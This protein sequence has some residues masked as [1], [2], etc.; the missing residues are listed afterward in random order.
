MVVLQILHTSKKSAW[1]Q[2][3]WGAWGVSVNV[4]N[5]LLYVGSDLHVYTSSMPNFNCGCIPEYKWC[6]SFYHII[7]PRNVKIIGFGKA[8]LGMVMALERLLGNHISEGVISIPV[9]SLEAARRVFPYHISQE[10][11]KIRWSPCT[12]CTQWLIFQAVSRRRDQHKQSWQVWLIHRIRESAANN[13]PDAAAE[14]AAK[15]ILA[16]ARRATADDLVIVLISGGGSAL[17]PC[18]VQGVTLQEK[19]QVLPIVLNFLQ[20]QYHQEYLMTFLYHDTL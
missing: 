16:V 8:V 11:S 20:N 2:G 9:G 4:Y 13:L 14:R 3:L 12:V 1:I 19:R 17:L 7:M 18:P 6:T 5:Y 15:E 10:N